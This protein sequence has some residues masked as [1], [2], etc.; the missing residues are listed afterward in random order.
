MRYLVY[1]GNHAKP[2]TSSTCTKY[3]IFHLFVLIPN[4]SSVFSDPFSCEK[5]KKKYTD[6]LNNLTE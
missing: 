5:K 3:Y 2:F 1:S 6:E 4:K